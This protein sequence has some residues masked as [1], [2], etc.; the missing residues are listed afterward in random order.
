M[1]KFKVSTSSFLHSVAEK[2][3]CYDPEVE[4]A[5]YTVTDGFYVD[6]VATYQCNESQFYVHIGGDLNRTCEP[7]G[8]WSNQ[9]P[10]CGK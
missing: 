2:R 4:N 3:Q 10:I 1:W 8:N 9:E 7:S 6:S 5:T